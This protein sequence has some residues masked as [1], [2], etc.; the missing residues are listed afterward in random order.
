MNIPQPTPHPLKKIIED[1]RL[2]LWQIRLLVDNC[3]SES[4]LSRF[5]NGIEVM[6][7]PLENKLRKAIK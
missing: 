1:K 6:P 5:L 7:E 4:R 2:T 3:P